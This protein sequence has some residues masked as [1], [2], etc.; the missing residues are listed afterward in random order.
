MRKIL[1]V[2]GLLT[3]VSA[4]NAQTTFGVHA[5]GIMASG[6]QE[7]GD[8]KSDIKSLMSWKIGGVAT[9]GLSENFQFMP[10]L[11]ILSKGGKQEESYKEDMG[12]G[13]MLEEKEE[14]KYKLT[15]VE[16]PLN[17]V[18]NSGSFFIGAGPSISLGMSGKADYKYTVTF[19]GET[20]SESDSYDIKFDGDKDADDEAAH[21]KMFEFGANVFAGY[22]LSNG[23]FISAQYNHGLSNISPYEETT[24]KNKYV[25]IGV[26]YFFGGK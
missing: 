4:A 17:F 22:K 25:G 21:L 11:N 18:Y 19:D 16:I 24:W 23:I 9:I 2:F 6:T 7:F 5:N 3:A 15:Y 26:G 14:V 10:Q 8:E 20:E 13:M 12:G 1:F